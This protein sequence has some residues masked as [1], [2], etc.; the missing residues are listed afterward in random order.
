M[1][2]LREMPVQSLNSGTAKRGLFLR[3]QRAQGLERGGMKHQFIAD[4]HQAFVAQQQL[5]NACGRESASTPDLP[6]TSCIAGDGQAAPRETR[7][8]F[9]PTASSSSCLSETLCDERRTVSASSGQCLASARAARPSAR[10]ARPAAACCAALPWTAPA[11]SGFRRWNCFRCSCIVSSLR[12][13][14]LRDRAAR[15]AA[16]QARS[17]CGGRRRPF[18]YRLRAIPC[19]PPVPAFPF[20]SAIR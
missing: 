6:S 12:G 16:S 17:D 14:P 9:S 15:I 19:A 13:D 20:R 8:R 18:E 1:A 7:F 11:S 3:Q 2:Y 4:A 5:Q 10:A